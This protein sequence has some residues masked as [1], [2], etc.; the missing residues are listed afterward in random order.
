VEVLLLENLI[1]IKSTLLEEIG[2]KKNK[3]LL[4]TKLRVRVTQKEKFLL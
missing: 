3:R 1:L 4:I 2:T